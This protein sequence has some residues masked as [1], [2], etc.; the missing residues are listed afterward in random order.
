MQRNPSMQEQVVLRA[1]TDDDADRLAAFLNTCTLRH[2]G[3][4]RSSPADARVTLY[5]HSIDPA[6]DSRLALSDDEIVGF[7][8]VWEADQEEMRLYA[9]THPD[10]TGRGI[11]S[12][13]LAFC[14]GRACELTRGSRELTTTSWAADDQAPGLLS[15]RGFAPVRYFLQMRIAGEE[16][17][18]RA[19][20]PDDITVE[21]CSE[22]NVEDAALYEAWRAAFTGHWGRP[23]Q[24]P[25][26]FWEER[27]D[28]G[29]EIFPFDP[30]LWFVS[31]S[32][33]EV[34]GFVLCEQNGDLGRVA[35][36]GVVDEFRGRG[37]G[38]ALLTHG[39]HELRG[40]G[41]TEIVLDVDAENVTSAL[42]LYRKAGM[43]E[44]P[45]FTIWGKEIQGQA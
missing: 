14:E 13:L 31:S 36:L 35:E 43:T 44:H 12:A 32:A 25:E 24:G 39:F 40:R 6:A 42:R 2:Q 5:E 18:R 41:A 9:R 23:V 30:S 37:L 22:G 19:A 29:R 34:A 4:A 8:R 26:A 21:A 11:G 1:A 10:A 33:G 16:L 45:S 28:A 17:P 7:A 20:W 38:L 27:R 15:A 3:V